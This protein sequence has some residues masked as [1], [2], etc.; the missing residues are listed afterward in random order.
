MMRKMLLGDDAGDEEDDFFLHED[1]D[2][3]GGRGF[4]EDDDEDGDVHKVM[5]FVPRDDGDSVDED[6]E[7][8]AE[9]A[10]RKRLQKKQNKKEK[11]GEETGEEEG[12]LKKKGKGKADK[13]TKK[14]RVT[15]GGSDEEGEEEEEE[16]ADKEARQQQLELLF[17][18]EE[19][20][21][22]GDRL[23]FSKKEFQKAQKNKDGSKKQK[24]RKRLV[25]STASPLF[26]SHL[27]SPSLTL[28]GAE[29]EEDN[30]FQLNLQD[31]RFHAVLEGSNAN[32]GIDPLANEF[33]ATDGMQSLLNEQ[34][35]R[36]QE[37]MRR[38]EKAKR[39]GAASGPGGSSEEIETNGNGAGEIESL[40]KKLKAKSSK[41]SVK[42]PLRR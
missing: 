2:E 39:S 23:R 18:G 14:G 7:T 20:N 35:K 26:F 38:E 34:H 25:P 22:T 4:G 16:E 11:K 29:V 3:E 1:E 10:K 28:R 32:F 12:S 31:D 15:R 17:A 13:K 33:R 21:E 37:K 24:K 40:V 6:T 19:E 30:S 42:K 27:T 36:R 5:S 41:D 8:P 9:A